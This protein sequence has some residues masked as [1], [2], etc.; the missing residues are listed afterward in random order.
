MA[1]GERIFQALDWPSLQEEPEAPGG[2]PPRLA[3]AL[4]FEQLSFAYEAGTPV[5]KGLTFTVPAEH[6]G[7]CGPHGIGEEY[8]HSPRFPVCTRS[9][10][11]NSLS[12]MW[13]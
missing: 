10:R 13:T 5:L 9:I 12:M 2:A 6:G 1:S 7:H 8:A 3:G 4:R 11:A